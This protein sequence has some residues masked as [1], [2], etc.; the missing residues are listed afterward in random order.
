VEQNYTAKVWQEG[1]WCVAQCLEVDIVSKGETEEEALANLKEALELH[2]EP[3]SVTSVADLKGSAGSL[4]RPISWNEIIQIAREDHVED[5]V[6][7][8]TRSK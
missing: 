1:D 6:I 3:Q 5:H 2:F 4:D 7:V 8:K